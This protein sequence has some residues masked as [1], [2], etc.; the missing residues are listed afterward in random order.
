MLLKNS[1][2][3]VVIVLVDTM[4][5][6]RLKAWRY[7]SVIWHIS[8]TGNCLELLVIAD[9]HAAISHVITVNSRLCFL[10]TWNFLK[11]TRNGW[12]ASSPAQLFPFTI[13][14]IYSWTFKAIS[15]NN[16]LKQ[17]RKKHADEN[18]ISG[19]LSI[20]TTFQFM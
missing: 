17:D 19:F 10:F 3:I 20:V 18:E 15:R 5:C 4:R 2:H 1:L 14:E 7:H 12:L 9:R 6:D 13:T 8:G 16:T 11:L